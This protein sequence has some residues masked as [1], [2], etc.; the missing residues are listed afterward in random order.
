MGAVEAIFETGEFL[1]SVCLEDV[2][3][4]A[5]EPRQF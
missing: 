1:A 2:L 5:I 3:E 4:V